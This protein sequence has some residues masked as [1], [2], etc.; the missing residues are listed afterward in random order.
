MALDHLPQQLRADVGHCSCFYALDLRVLFAESGSVCEVVLLLAA[1]LPL[2]LRRVCAASAECL[3]DA[4]A[5]SSLTRR[6]EQQKFQEGEVL[7]EATRYE[8]AKQVMAA[9]A[10]S[11]QAGLAVSTR[12]KAHSSPW[13]AAPPPIARSRA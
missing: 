4:C 2:L 11:Q 10:G 5:A 3:Q 7:S 6:G 9:A 12:K 13:I 1:V 8:P